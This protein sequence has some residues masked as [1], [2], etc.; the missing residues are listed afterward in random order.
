MIHITKC[1]IYFSFIYRYSELFNV[2]CSHHAADVP[3]CNLLRPKSY[4][5]CAHLLSQRLLLSVS[6]LIPNWQQEVG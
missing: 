2:V 5:S 3:I 4:K 1:S 6:V